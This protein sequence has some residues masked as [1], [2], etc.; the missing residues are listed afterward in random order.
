MVFG[1]SRYVSLASI[2]SA[3]V[4]PFAT[5]Y[6]GNSRQMIVVAAALG[7]LAFFK[8]KANIQ[9]LLSGTEHRFGSPR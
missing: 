2:T 7:M 8:H 9:R 6:L 4:L 3:L 5:W 1:I